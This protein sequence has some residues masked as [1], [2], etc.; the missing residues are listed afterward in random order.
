AGNYG[1]S[2]LA[3]YDATGAGVDEVLWLDAAEHRWIEELSA[4]NVFIVEEHAHSQPT[5]VTPPASNTILDGI[6]RASVLELAPR[7]GYAVREAPIELQQWRADATR[8]VVREAFA[9]GTAAVVVPIG[10][11]HDND[12][13]WMI[14]DGSP[15]PVAIRLR[16]A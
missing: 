2:L 3:K 10:R 13:Q 14:G 9:T 16:A 12:S 4:M 5:L 8:G 6:T 15:G 7:L 11:V 1:A